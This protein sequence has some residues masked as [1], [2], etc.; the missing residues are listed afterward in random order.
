MIV[1]VWALPY[2]PDCDSLVW[3]NDPA[4]ARADSQCILLSH[5]TE[6]LHFIETAMEHTEYGLLLDEQAGSDYQRQWNDRVIFYG[7]ETIALADAIR[8]SA[9]Y[10]RADADG[11]TPSQEEVSARLDQDQLR[12]E[13]SDDFIQLVKLAQNQDLAGFRKLV[14]ET[15]NPD[16][17]NNLEYLAPYDLM[18][19]LEEI[20]WRQWEQWQKEREAYLESFGRKP[21]WQEILPAKLRREM[22]I[23]RLESAVLDASADG[24]DGPYAE[25][26]RL[27]WLAYQ[28]EA[29]EEASIELTLAA[30]STVSVDGALA[31]LVEFLTYEQEKLMEE[32]ER[33]IERR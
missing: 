9:L 23:P 6:R 7:A 29:L 11:H 28:Q 32:Y 8:D 10:Q 16:I 2:R 5:Y 19:T 31:Y 1:A 18:E 30:P 20:D 4:I 25:V 15:K 27:A 26:P 14:E 12:W 17:I 22:A 33:F 13:S 24:P 21:Y 3:D